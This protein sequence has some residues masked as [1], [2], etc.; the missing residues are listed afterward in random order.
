MKGLFTTGKTNF[1]SQLLNYLHNPD[2]KNLDQIGFYFNPSKW[3]PSAADMNAALKAKPEL[4]ITNNE[5][6]W[7]KYLSFVD[8]NIDNIPLGDINALIDKMT[9]PSIF[10][11]I[12][13]PI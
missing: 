9:S 4:F 5:V 2:I 1:G 11:K 12:I 3:T 8:D 10:N 6:I 13:N 7:R